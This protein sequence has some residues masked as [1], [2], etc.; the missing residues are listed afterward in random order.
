MFL[1]VVS[2]GVMIYENHSR[3][4]VLLRESSPLP[5]SQPP[6]PSGGKVLPRTAGGHWL[7]M[8]SQAG[9]C[10]RGCWERCPELSEQLR[11][12]PSVGGWWAVSGARRPSQ[13]RVT[14]NRQ[15]APFCL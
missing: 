4:V 10:W 2:V 8:K 12:R 15:G 5:A 1:A 14:N 11:G 13:S 7:V 3:D 6:C 9:L